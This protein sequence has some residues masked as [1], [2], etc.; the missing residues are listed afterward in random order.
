MRPAEAPARLG[1]V[2]MAAVQTITSDPLE[3]GL[4]RRPLRK[5]GRLCAFAQRE[6]GEVAGFGVGVAGGREQGRY[7]AWVEPRLQWAKV[8]TAAAQAQVVPSRAGR[9]ADVRPAGGTR[10]ARAATSADSR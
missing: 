3:V 9:L 4:A 10:A 8:R 5:R 2:T 6:D 7:G 1:A